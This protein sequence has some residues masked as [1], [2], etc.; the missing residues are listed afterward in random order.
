[1][2]SDAS[3]ARH[4]EI[5]SNSP[6]AA[7]RPSSQIAAEMIGTFIL[8]FAGCGSAM[9]DTKSQGSITHFGVSVSFGLVVMIVIYSIGHISG[10]HI[11]PAVTI[12]F[13]TVRHFP[14]SQVPAYIGAQLLSAIGAAFL[15]SA[16]FNPVANIG[17]TIPA[18]SAAQSFVLEILITYILMFVVSAV[19]TDTRAIGEL[20]GLAVGSTVALNAI[21]AGPISGASMNP[22]RSLGP[23][24]AAN[25][26]KSIWVYIVG[27]TLGAV[28]GALS[29]NMIRL[30]QE[31]NQ[32]IEPRSRSFKR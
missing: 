1:M 20:A 18:G 3:P 26:Y 7:V 29:Y 13:A 31:E 12:A 32:K 30:P 5:S 9:V 14:W 16:I 6:V 23:A 25:N 10:A 2:T 22:A 11:N 19:A 8:V 21:F 27:P 28:L 17:A 24:I 15:L 4:G